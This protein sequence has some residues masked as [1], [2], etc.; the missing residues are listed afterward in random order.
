MHH[1]HGLTIALLGCLLIPAMGYA[2]SQ[3]DQLTKEVVINKVTEESGTYYLEAEEKLYQL[4]PDARVELCKQKRP[5][6]DISQLEGHKVTLQMHENELVK[7]VMFLC[8]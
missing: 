8:I 3:P 7:K 6:A 2:A 5:L 1:K 4:A